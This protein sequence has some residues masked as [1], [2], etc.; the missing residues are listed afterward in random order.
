MTLTREGF[1]PPQSAEAA[2]PDE[3]PSSRLVSR[4]DALLLEVV[5]PLRYVVAGV[6]TKVDADGRNLVPFP[7]SLAMSF[8]ATQTQIDLVAAA[9]RLRGVQAIIAAFILVG[10][11]VAIGR[12]LA[13]IE[14]LG[15]AAQRIGAGDETVE[16]GPARTKEAHQLT[17]GLAAIQKQLKRSSRDHRPERSQLSPRFGSKKTDLDGSRR[18]DR[19]AGVVQAARQRPTLADRVRSPRGAHHILLVEDNP[20]NRSVAVGMLEALDCTVICAEGGLA[21]LAALEV[22]PFDL[23]FMDI[24]MPGMDGHEATR[25][26]RAEEDRIGASPTPIIALTAHSQVEDRAASAEAGM[27][28]HISKPFTRD[29][30]RQA[31]QEWSGSRKHEERLGG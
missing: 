14:L 16:L 6:H 23:V 8:D 22:E 12:A 24:Q 13:P 4:D 25:R 20:V 28:G 3:V 27:N 31:I 17:L 7:G 18:T 29:D 2:Q 30:L 10:A 9:Q 5:V 19:T 15:D 26:I 21:S 1:S 11:W